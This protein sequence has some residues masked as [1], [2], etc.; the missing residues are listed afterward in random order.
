MDRR[1]DRQ[2]VRQVVAV[3]DQ[4]VVPRDLDRTLR[5]GLDRERGVVE[6][7]RVGDRA[8]APHGRRQAGDDLLGELAHR[9]LVPVDLR[10]SAD[11]PRPR[12]RHH[13]RDH[14]VQ[15]V[16]VDRRGVERAARERLGGG[17]SHAPHDQTVGEQEYAAREGGGAEEL[18]SG[19]HRFTLPCF[20]IQ[21]LSSITLGRRSGKGQRTYLEG[22]TDRTGASDPMDVTYGGSRAERPPDTLNVALRTQ[23]VGI[24]GSGGPRGGRL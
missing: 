5:A 8:V 9:Q 15:H 12:P 17:R 11:R 10:A 24:R 1:V 18:A 21:L 16:L 14:E 7:L 23:V 22:R 2:Q 19:Q 13:R 20:E 4:L 6:R 3:L